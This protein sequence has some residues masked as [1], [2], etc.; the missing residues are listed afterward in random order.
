MTD[1]LNHEAS[2]WL[3]KQMYNARK[4]YTAPLDWMTPPVWEG[5]QKYWESERFKK[6]SEANKK[7]RASSS[8]SSS[9]VYR[10]GSVSTAVHVRRRV[11]S[12]KPLDCN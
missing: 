9:L 5:L 2:E 8:E 3:K 6:Q 12:P 1:E 11:I 4:L 10:G 7:N